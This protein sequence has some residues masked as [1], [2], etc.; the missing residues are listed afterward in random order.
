MERLNGLPA[1]RVPRNADPRLPQ[2]RPAALLV[3]ITAQVAGPI[4]EALYGNV[5]GVIL[6]EHRP[7]HNIIAPLPP[8]APA[9]HAVA[10]TQ[11][12]HLQAAARDLDGAA[13]TANLVE[14]LAALLLR[15]ALHPQ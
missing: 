9:P 8:R 1:R 10:K 5:G 6:I 2:Q 12:I 14:V 4:G 15:T 11:S 7:E 13:I 3:E